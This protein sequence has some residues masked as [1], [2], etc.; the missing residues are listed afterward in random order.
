MNES[1]RTLKQKEMQDL[2]QRMMQF[3][4]TAMQDIQRKQG[5]LLQPI[6]KKAQDAISEVA[7]SGSY[8]VIF[9]ESGGALAYYDEALVKD[10]TAEVKTKLGITQ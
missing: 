9:D 8:T 2:Q 6:L 1:I 10:L 3:E 5:E 7:K 4:Q